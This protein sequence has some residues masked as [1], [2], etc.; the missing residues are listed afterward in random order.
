[1]ATKKATYKS[2]SVDNFEYGTII[3]Y[4][5]SALFFLSLTAFSISS[6][7]VNTVH[8]VEYCR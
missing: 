8:I 7:L 1:M 3:V 5:T 6:V 2:T 4:S